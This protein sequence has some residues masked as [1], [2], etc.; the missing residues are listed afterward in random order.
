VEE[1]DLVTRDTTA[2]TMTANPKVNANIPPIIKKV[3]NHSD[4]QIRAKS[5]APSVDTIKT[6]FIL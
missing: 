2:V 6:G 5:S 1:C 4:L 3:D